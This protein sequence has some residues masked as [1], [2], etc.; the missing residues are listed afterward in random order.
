METSKPLLFQE[1]FSN[2][3]TPKSSNGVRCQVEADGYTFDITISIY[4]LRIFPL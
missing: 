2:S 4:L 1:R 3:Q